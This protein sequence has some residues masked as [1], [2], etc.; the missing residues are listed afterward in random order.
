MKK[1]VCIVVQLF[2]PENQAMAVRTKFLANALMDSGY[3]TSVLTSSKSKGVDKYKVQCAFTPV[4]TNK[5]NVYLRLAKELIYSAEIFIRVLFHPAKLFIISSPPFTIS[6]A[7]AMACRLRGK[8]FVFDVRD[9][10]PEVYFIEGLLNP[11]GK[12]GKMLKRIETNL[13]KDSIVTTTV[14]DRIVTKLKSKS[15][16]DDKIYLLRNG[17]ADHIT[18]IDSISTNPFVILFHGNM[19][20][21]QNPQL[22]VEVAKGCLSQKLNVEFWVYGWGNQTQII[23]DAVPELSNL[24]HKG[25]LSHDQIPDI[26]KHTSL[27]ISFQ[28]NTEISKN[29]FPSKVMEFIGSGIP[30]IV[31]PISEAGEFVVAP[32]VGFQFSPE[33]AGPIVEC[34]KQLSENPDQIHEMSLKT[35]AIRNKLSRKSVSDEFA[36]HLN[37]LL[38]Q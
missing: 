5:D 30:V 8:Q 1:S 36:K 9:E 16:Q 3:E 14:T 15:G 24:S 35:K 19:G 34:I 12:V 28:G 11:E 22:I 2:Y 27:G 4:S 25:E 20:K 37:D 21:F 17:Y 13:Y 32:G 23:L 33:D 6:Y 31:T 38:A 29:S 10:Y 7:A 26:L 18:T